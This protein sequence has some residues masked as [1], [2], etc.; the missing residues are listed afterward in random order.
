MLKKLTVIK[1]IILAIAIVGCK[2]LITKETEINYKAPEKMIITDGVMKVVGTA[3]NDK[4]G[5]I[6]VNEYGVFVI[7]GL[8]AWYELY[9]NKKTCVWGE[10]KFIDNSVRDS[11][12]DDNGEWGM[13]RSQSYGTYYTISNATWEL[14]NDTIPNDTIK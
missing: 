3:R 11:I 2:S 9:L 8:N 13:I 6:I 4:G 7:V 14:C 10:V 5:A 12:Q 1:L